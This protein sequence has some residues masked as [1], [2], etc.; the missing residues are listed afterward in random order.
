MANK[1]RFLLAVFALC[2]TGIL[3]L[4][5]RAFAERS[6]KNSFVVRHADIVG[7]LR[8][9][10]RIGDFGLKNSKVTALVRRDS[11]WL[12]DFW[13]QRETRPTTAQ[14]DGVTNADG[15]W[16]IA[17]SVH[18][19]KKAYPINYDEVTRE[20]HLIRARDKLAIAG[21]MLAIDTEYEL[22]GEQA[23]LLITTRLGLESGASIN[24]R[25]RDGIKW[26]NTDYFIDKEPGPFNNYDGT[27]RWVGRHGLNGDLRFVRLGDEPMEL[28]FKQTYPGLAPQINSG[29]GLM[30]VNPGETRTIKR[31]LSYEALPAQKADE[32]TALGKLIVDLADERG[33]ALASKLTFDGLDDTPDPDFGNDG[34][35]LG[36]GRFSFSGAGHFEVELPAGSYR[37]IATAGIERDAKTW[38]VKL[39]GGETE[40]LEGRLPRVIDTPGWISAD[41]HLHQV[42]SVDADLAHSGRIIAV[43]AEGVE[44]AAATDHY[45]VTDLGPTVAR[46]VAEGRLARPIA[47]MVGSEV[48]TTGNRFGHFN[49]FPMDVD[50]WVRFH[51]T[52]PKAMFGEMREVSPAGIIQVNHPRWKG[53]GYFRVFEMDPKTHRIPVKKRDEYDSDFDAIEVFNGLD[54]YSEPLIR[55]VMRDW[56][57]LLG[58][59]HRY[60]ATGN[61]DSHKLAFQDAGLPRNLI[62]YG[63]PVSDDQDLSAKEREVIES[64]KQGRVLVTSGPIIDID[65]GGAG[66]GDT[67]KSG[68]K[69][70]QVSVRVRAAPWVD[71]QRVEVLMGPKAESV[72]YV[73]IKPSKK[74]VRYQ[75]TFKVPGYRKTFLVVIARGKKPLF[76]VYAR[77]VKPFAFTNPI[78]IEP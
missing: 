15:I 64:I 69:P 37:V 56:M 68:G 58:Q 59:G 22:M 36:V 18:D 26:G 19:G 12:V 16:Q 61:S 60:T 5:A 70:V 1:A 25:F 65:S 48:S 34:N 54:A 3:A 42:A 2:C 71:V 8:I 67:V 11:G 77:G 46:L 66:P 31:R 57:G 51:D 47:T 78:W 72:R 62:K 24:I 21:S 10:A 28:A 50:D 73:P 20:D 33:R 29:Y 43:A 52:T 9:G 4:V 7:R 23:T 38:R 74:L 40:R 35:E 32:R 44:L 41:L 14:L 76:N 45:A 39:A 53:I 63:P 75:E 30:R 6:A 27:A 49:L 17:P 13:P 55:L